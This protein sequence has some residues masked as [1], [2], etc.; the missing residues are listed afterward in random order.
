MTRHWRSIGIGVLRRLCTG[1]TETYKR[2]PVLLL[3]ALFDR[4]PNHFVGD[5][6]LGDQRRPDESRVVGDKNVVTYEST[7]P[8][9]PWKQRHHTRIYSPLL[10][11]K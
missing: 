7:H 6:D 2:P 8:Q 4:F 10:R 1:P 3:F 9:G 11:L 5:P